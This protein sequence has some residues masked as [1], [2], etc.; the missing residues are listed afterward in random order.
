MYER[1]SRY[2][3]TGTAELSMRDGRTIIHRRRR[4]LPAGDAII[5]QTELTVTAGDRLDAI[6]HRTLGDAE[7][8]WRIC[9]ANNA[10]H[11]AQLTAEPGR[12][13]RIP[14]PGM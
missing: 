9:D 2:A 8:Y 13:L 6:A 14:M 10:M 7:V 1:P 11:P 3:S 5:P 12:S 4:L